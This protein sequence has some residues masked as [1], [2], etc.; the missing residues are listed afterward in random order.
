MLPPDT[1]DCAEARA[2]KNH[3]EPRDII[4]KAGFLQ[5]PQAQA[6]ALLAAIVEHSTDAIYSFDVRG[7]VLTW[8]P[9]A[10]RLFGY[11]S[12]EIIGKPIE[13]LV[14]EG[15]TEE[16]SQ[17]LARIHAGERVQ[18]FETVQMNRNEAHVD[19]ALTLSP[20]YHDQNR[21]TGFS[22]VARD[23]RDQRAAEQERQRLIALVENSPD[24]IGLA[25]REQRLV[26]LNRS[27]KRMLNMAKVQDQ[28]ASVHRGLVL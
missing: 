4:E 16:L 24:L 23:I 27:G 14:P 1:K 25:D 28:G 11:S 13:L 22:A 2:A 20:V 6:E 12:E 9:A 3:S 5:L 15:R 17:I 18:H 19:V 7:T 10:E 8:N 26:F 21:L